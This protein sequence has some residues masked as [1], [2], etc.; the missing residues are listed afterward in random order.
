M[1]SAFKKRFEVVFLVSHPKGPKMS[2]RQ[3]AKYTK[4]SVSFVNK[5]TKRYKECGN[6]DDEPSKGNKRTNPK[7]VDNAICQLFIKNPTLS[8]RQAKQMLIRKGVDVSI[9]TIRR[10]LQE[11]GICNRSIN[12]KPLLSEKHVQKVYLGHKRTWGV[13]GAKS[14]LQMNPLFLFSIAGEKLGQKMGKDCYNEQL[15]ILQKS[16]CMD[17]SL[18]RD[19]E[20]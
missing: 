19:L 18:K 10:R 8:L 20:N 15:S 5:W 6:V 1:S 14:S 11:S 3:V 12:L 9:A 13:I 16:M 2:V 4:S 17:A 7:K